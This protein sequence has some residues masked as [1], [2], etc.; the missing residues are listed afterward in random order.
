MPTLFANMDADG[1]P[2][3]VKLSAVECRHAELSD[4][5]VSPHKRHVNCRSASSPLPAIL[6]VDFTHIDWILTTLNFCSE[7]QVVYTFTALFQMFRLA[8]F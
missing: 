2:L 6:S 1:W 7:P 5:L 4:L 3:G 8:F